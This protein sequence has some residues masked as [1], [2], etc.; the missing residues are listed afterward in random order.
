MKIE[1]DFD[2]C[3]AHGTCV[4]ACPEVFDLTDD[5]ELVIL[6]YNPDESL[7]ESVVAAVNSCPKAALRVVG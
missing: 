6:N 7:R 2:A 1:A 5:D 4:D 3:D